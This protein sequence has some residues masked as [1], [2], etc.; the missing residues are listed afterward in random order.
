MRRGLSF[1]F[2]IV[3]AFAVAA[4]MDVRA[5]TPTGRIAFTGWVAGPD[6][7]FAP[8]SIVTVRATVVARSG[9]CVETRIDKPES[10]HDATLWLC[11]HAANDANPSLGV[12][13]PI[14]ARA[15][16]TGVKTT[17]KGAAPLSDSFILLAD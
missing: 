5:A 6:T 9:A 15:R 4:L 16:I 2:V 8:G 14:T 1:A 17:A 10:G 13:A 11:P 12:G 7:P 3:L